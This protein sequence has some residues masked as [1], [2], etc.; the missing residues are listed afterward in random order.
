MSRPPHTASRDCR[1]AHPC[2]VEPCV[3]APEYGVTRKREKS[4]QNNAAKRS[5]SNP[6]FCLRTHAAQRA[7]AVMAG[8]AGEVG[9]RF[10]ERRE[11]EAPTSP[12]RHVSTVRLPP[13]AGKPATTQATQKRPATTH[14]SP[15]NAASKRCRSNE[16][17][18]S[19]ACRWWR[20]RAATVAASQP[21]PDCMGGTAELPHHRHTAHSPRTP[22]YP[23]GQFAGRFAGAAGGG[24]PGPTTS[25]R[26]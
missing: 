20:T 23:E 7:I 18:C 4:W 10:G 5:H 13:P 3:P 16:S 25:S 17:S 6:H 24:V 15:V 11:Y 8:W 2:P 14:A 26:P 1:T 19:D 9:G 12:T 21:C 22:V